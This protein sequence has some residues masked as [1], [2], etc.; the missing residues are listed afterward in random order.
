MM[1][2]GDFLEEVAFNWTLKDRQD[3]RH[4]EMGRMGFHSGSTHSV[5]KVWTCKIASVRKR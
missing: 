2:Q 5:T 1:G 4:A 3:S